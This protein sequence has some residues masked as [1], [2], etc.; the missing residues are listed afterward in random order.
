MTGW[1]G[2]MAHALPLDELQRVMA[3]YRPQGETPA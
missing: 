1:E 2:H 3:R